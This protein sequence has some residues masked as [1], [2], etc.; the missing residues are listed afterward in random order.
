MLS[1]L[2]KTVRQNV[3]RECKCHG[4][5]E[6]CTVRTCW[7]RLADFRR[8]GE[9]LKDKFDS[10]SMVEFEQNNNRNGHNTRKGKPAFRPKN[11]LHKPPT[12]A[13]LVYYEDS[14]NFC[15]RNPETGSL[16]TQGRLCNN[17]SLGTD[18]C[19]LMCCGRGF[20]TSES[21]ME[22]LC[23]CRFFWCCKVKC[24]NCRLRKVVHRCN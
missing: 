7:K 17:T 18:G 8:I 3:V 14:P 2:F 16:G 9:V 24:Q 20:T 4:V 12:Q 5:S 10:A 23:N 15:Q 13:D 19:D 6:A 21:E 1:S 11:K 22:E